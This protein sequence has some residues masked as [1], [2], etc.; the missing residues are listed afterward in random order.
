M[1]DET[2]ELCVQ[3]WQQRFEI[4]RHIT[5]S[6]SISP[7]VKDDM[8][9]SIAERLHGFV[10]SDLINL[11][12]RVAMSLEEGS[13]ASKSDFEHELLTMKPASLSEWSIQ[14][15]K[16]RLSEFYASRDVVNFVKVRHDCIS[17]ILKVAFCHGSTT[18]ICS[19]RVCVTRTTPW[20]SHTW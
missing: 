17:L 15:P 13:L 20:P 14:V 6:F 2:V 12:N 18:T 16:R 4:L 7:D 1:F 11:C 9:S 8:L 10:A 3:S 19:E 5:E